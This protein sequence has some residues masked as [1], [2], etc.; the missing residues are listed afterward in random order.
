MLYTYFAG[1]ADVW[2]NRASRFSLYHL[3]K[4]QFRYKTSTFLKSSSHKMASPQ[5]N[6][7]NVHWKFISI[8]TIIRKY[9]LELLIF[10]RQRILWRSDGYLGNR[11]GN[12]IMRKQRK[13]E[14]CTANK[15]LLQKRVWRWNNYIYNFSYSKKGKN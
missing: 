7:L 15:Q 1:S 2:R 14:F 8:N 12:K 10:I 4:S 11:N 13:N 3:I 5:A 6:V 9:Y